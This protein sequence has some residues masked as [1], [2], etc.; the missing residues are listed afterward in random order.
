MSPL[1]IL[2]TESSLGWGGQEI[3]VL[4]EARA[5]ASRG[6]AVT[7]AAPADSRIFQAAPKYGLEAIAI[8]IGRKRPGG[9]HAMMGLLR[10]RDFDVVNTHSS[11]DSWLAAIACRRASDEAS[12]TAAL[13]CS[14]SAQPVKPLSN[15]SRCAVSPAIVTE[16]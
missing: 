15:T 8:P 2:H 7:L 12:K 4:T 10:N 1:R 9:L 14:R 16:R 6:H 5:V 11:T 3:R 13:W